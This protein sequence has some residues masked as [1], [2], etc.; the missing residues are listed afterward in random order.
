METK[1]KVMAANGDSLPVSQPPQPQRLN[2]QGEE[3]LRESGNIEDLP[4]P[5]QQAEAEKQE[6]KEQAG[7]NK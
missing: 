6:K 7:N 2:K 3:Y 5:E 1:N 4:E